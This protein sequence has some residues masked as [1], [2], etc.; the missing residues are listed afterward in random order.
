V[1]ITRADYAHR[2]NE[3]P[4]Q[5]HVRNSMLSEAA[6]GLRLRRAPRRTAD[7]RMGQGATRQ[8]SAKRGATRCNEASRLAG[9]AFGETL[10]VAAQ[11][12]RCVQGSRLFAAFVLRF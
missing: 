5:S 2:D 1:A 3:A 8:G 6:R 10:T 4:R 7:E 12:A 9:L 11:G